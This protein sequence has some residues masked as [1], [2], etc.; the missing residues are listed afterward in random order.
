MAGVEREL[1]EAEREDIATHLICS[2][3]GGKAAEGGG[4]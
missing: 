4:L 1:T 3:R 2:V